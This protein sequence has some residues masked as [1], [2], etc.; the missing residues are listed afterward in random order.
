MLQNQALQWNFPARENLTGT[1]KRCDLLQTTKQC[2]VSSAVKLHV[3][4]AGVAFDAITWLPVA[5]L[6]N[7]AGWPSS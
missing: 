1:S 6:S 3:G 7:T 4:S 5:W 2:N